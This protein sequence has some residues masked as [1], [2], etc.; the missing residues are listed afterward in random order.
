MRHPFILTLTSVIVAASSASTYATTIIH[1][2]TSVDIEFVNIGNLDNTGDTANSVN[3]NNPGS[4]AYNYSIG[5][6]EVTA[7]QWSTVLSADSNIGNAGTWS[8]NQPTAN[9]SWYE[10]AKFANWL[11]SGDAL[12][13]AYSFSDA[14]TLT[15]ID[16]ATALSTY[17]TIYVLPNENEWYKAAYLKSDGSGYTLYATGDTLPTAGSDANY[18]SANSSPWNVGTGTI[19]NNGTY[20][21]GG[22]VWEWNED[23]FDGTLDNLSESRVKRG[24]AWNVN[25]NGIKS[26]HRSSTNPVTVSNLNGFRIAS[27]TNVAVPEPS[28]AAL[29]AI[30]AIACLAHKKRR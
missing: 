23:A 13:G 26:S 24:G 4:V 28:S 6:Y 3:G 8:G 18:D 2:S 15:G 22:N 16:R 17:G 30:G 27:I 29:L 5:K 25:S 7:A 21:M 9:T 14:T 20:D 10:A 11:T 1:D 19:E 12:I